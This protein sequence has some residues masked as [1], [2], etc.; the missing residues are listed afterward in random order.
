MHLLFVLFAQDLGFREGTAWPA[1]FGARPV[2]AQ[3][4][5]SYGVEPLL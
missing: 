1:S 5:L 4:T 2:G 3:Q